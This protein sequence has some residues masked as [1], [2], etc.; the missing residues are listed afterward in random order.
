MAFAVLSAAGKDTVCALDKAAQDKGRI[1][2]AG[3]HH[4]DCPQ[5]GRILEPGY[6]GSIGSCITTPVTEKTQNSGIKIIAHQYT[7]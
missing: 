7:S 5:V 3:T 6:P 4:P 2:P 1:N